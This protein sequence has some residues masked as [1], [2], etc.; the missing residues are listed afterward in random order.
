[1]LNAFD[2]TAVLAYKIMKDYDVFKKTKF[3]KEELTDYFKKVIKYAKEVGFDYQFIT[4]D[5]MV[6]ICD[7]LEG[8]C[9]INNGIIILDEENLKHKARKH[10]SMYVQ[11]MNFILQGCCI[12]IYASEVKKNQD[13]KTL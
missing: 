2:C 5:Q 7:R 4:G 1:M 3:T 12:R 9:K 13:T 11:G 6:E 10:A 8:F